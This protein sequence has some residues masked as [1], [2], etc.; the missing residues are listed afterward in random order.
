MLVVAGGDAAEVLQAA[1]GVLDEVTV[2]ISLLVIE[3]GALT[4]PATRYDR[5]PATPCSRWKSEW[6]EHRE[7][8]ACVRGGNA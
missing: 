5:H 8:V 3:H 4:I 2:T 1:E 7:D 6:S